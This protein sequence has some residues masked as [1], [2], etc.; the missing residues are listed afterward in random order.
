M[1]I[2]FLRNLHLIVLL[3]LEFYNSNE[4]ELQLEK[5]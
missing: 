5:N 4:I 1:G 2:Y 3:S